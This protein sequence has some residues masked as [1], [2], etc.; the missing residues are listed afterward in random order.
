M[1][2]ITLEAIP[3][4]AATDVMSAKAWFRSLSDLGLTF[5]ADDDVGDILGRD[6]EPLLSEAAAAKVDETMDRLHRAARGW[7]DPDFIYSLAGEGRFA[8]EADYPGFVL[9]RSIPDASRLGY[10]SIPGQDLPTVVMEDMGEFVALQFGPREGKL[11]EATAFRVV[12]TRGVRFGDNPYVDVSGA[13]LLFDEA[14]EAASIEELSDLAYAV[15]DERTAAR[16]AAP[17]A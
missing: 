11:S 4:L 13:E 3:D 7:T 17:G 5:H 16:R 12:P 8:T 6:G 14:R 2:R 15:L 9:D 10:V 1:S